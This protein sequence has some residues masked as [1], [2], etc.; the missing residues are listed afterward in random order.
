MFPRLCDN[1]F[2]LCLF[3]NELK[4]CKS[5]RSANYMI[6]KKRNKNDWLTLPPSCLLVWYSFLY[7]CCCC[8]II[9]HSVQIKKIQ[10]KFNVAIFLRSFIFGPLFSKMK[11]HC[12]E[13][14][15]QYTA[16][17]PFKSKIAK[18]RERKKTEWLSERASE[19]A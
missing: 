10:I 9:G 7:C 1:V 3:L 4:I 2:S 6:E 13:T 17:K 12:V 14:N 15:K 18:E 5:I 19:P 11:S 16:N 8:K